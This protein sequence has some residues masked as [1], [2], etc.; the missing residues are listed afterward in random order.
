MPA[1]PITVAPSALAHWHAINPTPPAAACLRFAVADWGDAPDTPE[2]GNPVPTDLQYANEAIV[3]PVR[4]WDRASVSTVWGGG[5]SK[6]DTL[7]W[8]AT[9]LA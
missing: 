4:A 3:D 1:G 6:P 7:W 5:T 2:Q 9:R 8:I